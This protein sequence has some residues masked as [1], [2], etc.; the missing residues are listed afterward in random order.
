MFVKPKEAAT[1]ILLRRREEAPREGFEVLMVLRSKKSKFVPSSY[2]FPGGALDDEDC[3][4]EAAALCRGLDPSRAFAALQDI[5]SPAMALGTWVAGIRETFEEVGLL[6]ACRNGD[7]LLAFSGEDA[8][9]Y[10][11]IRGL[12]QAGKLT[13]NEFLQKEGLTLATDRLY[14]YSHWITPWFFPIRYD[15]RFFVAET[16]AEQEARHDGIE[17]TGHLWI[18][19][20]D[21]LRRYH[22]KRFEM[23]FPTL[24]TMKALSQFMNIDEVIRS[25]SGKMISAESG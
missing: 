3:S 7:R 21:A 11:R 20:Q 9:R 24:M 6:M 22:E 5:D 18:T 10:C 2:V 13:F 15:V 12:L 14:Y 8:V 23:V 19:P 25:T 4:L 16:P 1:V 17:L